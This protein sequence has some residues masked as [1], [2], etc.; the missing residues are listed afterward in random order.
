MNKSIKII[1][2][3]GFVALI[4]IICLCVWS[5]FSTNPYTKVIE[6]NWGI[7]LP[8]EGAKDIYSYSEPSPHGDGIRYHV[9]DYPVGNETK[10]IQNTVF[11]LEKV[12]LHSIQPTVEQVLYVNQL[13]EKIDI[14]EDVIPDWSKCNLL[15]QKKDDNSELYLFYW[16]GTGT[17]YV[18]ESFL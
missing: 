5:Y 4:C 2:F 18:V 10:K 12:F 13:L 7:E 9:I 3:I 16:S 15:Y 6:K 8:A 11:S 1:L 14:T 17:L